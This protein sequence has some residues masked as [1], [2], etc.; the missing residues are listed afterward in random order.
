[1]GGMQ[2]HA[3]ESK[4]RRAEPAVSEAEW[5]PALHD[6]KQGQNLASKSARPTQAYEEKIKPTHC[7]V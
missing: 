4:P 7:A 5:V 1:M 6:Q 3:T 2:M